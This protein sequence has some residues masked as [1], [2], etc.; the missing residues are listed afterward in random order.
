MSLRLFGVALIATLA[1]ACGQDSGRANDASVLVQML[2]PADVTRIVLEVQPANVVREV[3]ASAYNASTGAFT[4]ML[5]VPAGSQTLSASA[6]AGTTL[7][8]TASAPVEVAAGATATVHLTIIDSRPPAPAP[9]RAPIITSF[10]VPVTTL[11]T[12]SSVAVSVAATDLDGDPIA[13]AWAATPAG[14]GVFA[15]SAAEATTFTAAAVG[16]CVVGVSATAKGRVDTASIDLAIT[17]PATTGAVAVDGAVFTRPE[18]Y[19]MDFI[20]GSGTGRWVLYRNSAEGVCPAPAVAGSGYTVG[21]QWKTVPQSVT[22]N[23]VDSCGGATYASSQFPNG[24]YTVQNFSWTP[25]TPPGTHSAC[26]ITVTLSVSG[27]PGGATLADSMSAGF[28]V[29][30]AS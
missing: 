11:A 15:D 14:C 4:A 21:V 27:L 9:D 3:S 20:P 8:G 30:P 19:L 5:T 28:E 2:T 6:Y 10:V 23:L 13:F 25:T 16:T 7:V 12:G 1:A 17:D 18:V 24:T 22:A 26:A 29:I